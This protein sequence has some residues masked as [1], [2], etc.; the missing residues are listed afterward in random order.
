VW[1]ITLAVVDVGLLAVFAVLATGHFHDS[2]PDD[3][4]STPPANISTDPV[5]FHMPSKNVYCYMDVNGVV[6]GIN[7]DA[8]A[9]RDKPWP[10]IATC[11]INHV[12]RIDSQDAQVVCAADVDIPVP[13][14]DGKSVG[15][16]VFSVDGHQLDYGQKQTVGDFTC[17]SRQAGVLCTNATGQWFNLRQADG[18][19]HGGPGEA[20][21]A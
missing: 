3:P 18:F 12:V 11:P 19:T 20:P 15:G 9:E 10:R 17:E 4:P 16:A 1:A 5:H 14:G 7:R 8:A 2:A 21:P 6:C 13:D